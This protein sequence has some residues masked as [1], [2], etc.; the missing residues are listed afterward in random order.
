MRRIDWAVDAARTRGMRIVLDMHH[1]RQL[2]GDPLDAGEFR[3]ADGI[4]EERF[5]A[6]WRQVA[7][8]YRTQPETVLFELYNEPHGA[9]SPARWNR[10]AA[11]T[12]AGIRAVD[13]TRY[14]I[15]GPAGWNSAW[16]LAA[17]VLPPADR[18]LLVTIHDYEPFD[19]THQG[20]EWAGLQDRTGITCCTDA[21]LARM[22][23]PLD[24]AMRWS[25]VWN[26]PVWVGEFGAYGRGPYDSRVRYTRA[27]R[28]AIEA[29][30]MTWAYWEFA[31]GF[32]FYDP[33][34][35]TVRTE[36]RDA[37]FRP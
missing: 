12:L 2:D 33:A 4:L 13:T 3:V 29:R 1:H 23:A 28:E 34:T 30:G 14:V 6:I 11:V 24:V 31:A 35:G 9:L 32:G 10:L 19:F 26:R 17:L 36:L 16:E 8:R 20:A 18:R 7:E 21:Q 5:A 37:L 15:I 27:A 25:E 22:V